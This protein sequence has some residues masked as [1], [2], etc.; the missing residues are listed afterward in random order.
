M[1]A[2]SLKAQRNP[3]PR[4]DLRLHPIFRATVR[5]TLSLW[6]VGSQHRISDD[7]TSGFGVNARPRKGKLLS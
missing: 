4:E 5:G 1:L 3:A 7:V 2:E 6:D